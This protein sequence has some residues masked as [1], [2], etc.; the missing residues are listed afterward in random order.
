MSIA[1]I[2]SRWKLT[3]T[4]GAAVPLT[5]NQS[6]SL[7]LGLFENAEVRTWQYIQVVVTTLTPALLGPASQ[8]GPRRPQEQSRRPRLLDCVLQ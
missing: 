6:D 1:A 3:K 2:Y 4:D 5:V 7:R 8:T